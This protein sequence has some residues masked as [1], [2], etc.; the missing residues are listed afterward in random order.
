MLRKTDDEMLAWYEK[1]PQL[2]VFQIEMLEL[3]DSQMKK[4]EKDNL[5]KYRSR[6]HFGVSTILSLVGR[7]PTA[8]PLAAK[9][10]TRKVPVVVGENPHLAYRERMK[11]VLQEKDKAQTKSN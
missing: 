2:H 7:H 8:E 3:S 5:Q 1:M 9:K 4:I 6:F 10:E 11:E